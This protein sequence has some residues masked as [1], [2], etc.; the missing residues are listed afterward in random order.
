VQFGDEIYS[1]ALLEYVKNIDQAFAAI[2]SILKL[3]G[4]ALIFVPCRNAPYARLNMMF[5]QN[6]KKSS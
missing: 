4:L 1:Q 2:A 3:G 6:F 5:A